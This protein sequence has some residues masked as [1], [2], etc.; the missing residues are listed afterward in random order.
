MLDVQHPARMAGGIFRHLDAER[1][2]LC[3]DPAVR[4]A[5]AEWLVAD[6]LADG[7]GAVTDWPMADRLADATGTVADRVVADGVADTWTRTLGPAQVLA[8]PRPADGRLPDELADAVLRVLLHRT[9]GHGQLAT[10]AAHVI[11]QAMIPAAA[12]VTRSQIR[13]FGGRSFDDIGHL[14]VA[15][16]F[17]VARSGKIHSRF[18]RLTSNLALD[19]LRHVCA[20]LAADREGRAEDLAAAEDLPNRAPGPVRT[21]EANEICAADIAAG[22]ADR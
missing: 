15:A 17:E 19:T 22:R 14:T 20:E 9:A 12:R 18:G 10:L 1:S 4:V 16:L 11:V 13:G 6:R 21:T 5:V 8:A 2:T 7:V 3:S